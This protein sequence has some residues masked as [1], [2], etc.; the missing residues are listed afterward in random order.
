MDRERCLQLLR[1][2]E[3]GRLAVVADGGPLIF[4]VNYRMDGDTIV[5]RTDPGLKLDKGPRA[6]ACFEIDHFDR[7]LRTGWSV[8]A[9]GRLE[10]VTRY[11]STLWEHLHELPVEPWADGAK[12]HW[13]RL[14]PTRVSGRIITR[15]GARNLSPE[16]GT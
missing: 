2:D 9:A 3:V 12:D 7:S 15:R 11:Q 13:L 4:P 14:V 6:R 1:E 10:E 16:E 8:I 5:L